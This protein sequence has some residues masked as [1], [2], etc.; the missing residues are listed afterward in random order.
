V[1]ARGRDAD[2]VHIHVVV[3]GDKLAGGVHHRVGVKGLGRW[4]SGGSN[5]SEAVA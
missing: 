5:K 1:G 3:L 2:D 4:F